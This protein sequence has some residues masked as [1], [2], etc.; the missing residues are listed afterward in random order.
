MNVLKCFYHQ[1]MV[2]LCLAVWMLAGCSSTHTLNAW[3]RTKTASYNAITDPMTWG[4]ALGGVLLDVTDADE[5]LSEYFVDNNVI[6]DDLD[7]ALLT[8]NAAIAYITAVTVPEENK[9]TKAKRLAVTFGAFGVSKITSNL[10]E[11]NVERKAPDGS[12][13]GLGSHHAIE[14]FAGSAVTRRN[15]AAMDLSP[16]ARYSIV[17]LSYTT[18]SLAALTRVQEEGH[19]FGDQLLNAAIGNFIGIF[20]SDVFMMEDTAVEVSLMEDRTYIGL[21]IPF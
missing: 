6:D 9:R 15:V 8:A 14:P 17:G 4:A 12:D 13:D 20:L 11:E 10:L 5:N 1:R 7:A 18:G 16:W 19:S 21:K 2:F 3:S